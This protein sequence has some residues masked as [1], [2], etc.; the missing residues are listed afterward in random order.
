MRHVEIRL[1]LLVRHVDVFRIIGAAP[2]HLLIEAVIAAVGS[3]KTSGSVARS[4]EGLC[5]V[6]D[7]VPRTK[8]YGLELDGFAFGILALR[9][10]VGAG[11]ALKK[12][13]EA[14]VLRSEE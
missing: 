11:I 14:A 4:E 13:I 9:N 3:R 1:R 7:D 2:R 6:V 8:A 12:I 5:G 10:G